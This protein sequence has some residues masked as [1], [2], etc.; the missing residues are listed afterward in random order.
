MPNTL[1]IQN[2]LNTN[3]PA[4]NISPAN[5]LKK[6][7]LALARRNQYVHSIDIKAL[8]VFQPAEAATRSKM[9]TRGKTLHAHQRPAILENPRI[10]S[11]TL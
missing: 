7:I 6:R 8:T 3:H 5:S 4:K 2:K 9:R 10:R 1:D 11:K